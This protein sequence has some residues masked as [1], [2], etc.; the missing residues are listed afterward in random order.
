M[1]HHSRGTPLPSDLSGVVASDVASDTGG[2]RGGDEATVEQAKGILMARHGIGAAAAATRLA[3]AARY[4]RRSIDEIAEDVIT[5]LLRRG[6][7]TV[8]APLLRR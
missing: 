4:A 8:T 2:H 7:Q 6:R 3:T 5:D 1:V